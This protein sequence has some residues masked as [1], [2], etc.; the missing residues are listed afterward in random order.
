MHGALSFLP[1]AVARGDELSPQEWAE[2]S[3]AKRL[4]TPA[5]MGSDLKVLVQGRG[6]AWGA[7]QRLATPP[8]ADA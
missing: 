8:P 7:Y 5:G 1:E 2:L 4:L 6:R 3:A